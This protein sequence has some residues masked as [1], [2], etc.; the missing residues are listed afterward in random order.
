MERPDGGAIPGEVGEGLY[1]PAHIGPV[2]EVD[3]VR[4]PTFDM[5]LRPCGERG[6]VQIGMRPVG[7]YVQSRNKGDH[8]GDSRGDGR[9]ACAR[10]AGAELHARGI[11]DEEPRLPLEEGIDRDGAP[12]SE[13]V[14]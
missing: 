7:G 10:V 8:R 2:R 5:P 13:I 12:V 4:P 11:A 3:Q 1:H 9:Y 6:K 14:H